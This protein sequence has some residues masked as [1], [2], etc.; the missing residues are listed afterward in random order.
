MGLMKSLTGSMG[1]IFLL[2]I[3]AIFIV[4]LIGVLFLG[5]VV[6]IG[7]VVALVISFFP[8]FLILLGLGIMYFLGWQGM[9]TKFI[10]LGFIIFIIGIMTLGWI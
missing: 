9:D 6:V 5:V 1:G 7:L 2:I 8:I 3:L 10:I 4:L